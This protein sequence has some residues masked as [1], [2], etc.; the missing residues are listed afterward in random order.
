MNLN[1]NKISMIE[2]HKSRPNF[3]LLYFFIAVLVDVVAAAGKCDTEIVEM[4]AIEM[5]QTNDVYST[6]D[7]LELNFIVNI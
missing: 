1:A 7:K 2:T 3:S 6:S 5:K 4:E